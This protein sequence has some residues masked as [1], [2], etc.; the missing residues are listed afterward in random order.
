MFG[1]NTTEKIRFD[2]K[3]FEKPDTSATWLSPFLS[4]F[5]ME[6]FRDYLQR[7]KLLG[8]KDEAL[9]D[10]ARKDYRK[11]Y[12]REKNREY[13]KTHAVIRVTVPLPIKNR[14]L[15]GAKRHQ[16]P[17]ARYVR[18]CALAYTQQVF[19]VPDEEQ[20]HR[21]EVGMRKIGTNINQIAHLCNAKRSVSYLNVLKLQNQFSELEKVIE[22]HLRKPM[23]LENLIKKELP[24]R[25]DLIQV[26]ERYII[27]QNSKPNKK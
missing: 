16:R 11:W 24:K 27:S 23:T 14:L 25:P 21:V 22:K 12:R 9:L 4:P 19:I 2:Q 3:D 8:I 5:L 18:E 1:W 15:R 10:Q 7:K 26:I 17:L 20:V 13:K 6:T